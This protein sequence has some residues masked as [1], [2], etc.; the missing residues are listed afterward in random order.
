MSAISTISLDRFLRLVGTPKCPDTIDVRTAE[1]F[2][3]DR[4]FIPAS[5]KRNAETSW[6]S[7]DSWAESDLDTAKRDAADVR[8]YS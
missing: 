7:S 1:E 3:T 6:S 8:R 5:L 2:A 4:R